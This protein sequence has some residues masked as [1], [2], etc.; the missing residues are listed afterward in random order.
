[1]GRKYR[2]AG[3]R[4]GTSLRLS[5][6]VCVLAPR[7]LHDTWAILASTAVDVNAPGS[8]S[9]AT[10]RS[11]GHPSAAAL[12]TSVPIAYRPLVGTNALHNTGM[13]AALTAASDIEEDRP[14]EFS[15]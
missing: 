5:G 3:K 9:V 13:A 10:I 12:R 14:L 8:M 6:T 1:M 15:P 4:P 7:I 2:L 11:I